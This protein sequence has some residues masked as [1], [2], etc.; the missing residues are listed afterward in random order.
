MKNKAQYNKT[1][2]NTYG[3]FRRAGAN[4]SPLSWIHRGI[5]AYH[6]VEEAINETDVDTIV[7]NEVTNYLDTVL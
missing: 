3:S 2:Q 4:S 1:S 7:S 6:L 5:K